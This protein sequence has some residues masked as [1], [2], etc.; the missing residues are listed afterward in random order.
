MRNSLLEEY[1]NK[2]VGEYGVRLLMVHLLLSIGFICLQRY[3]IHVAC[4][5]GHLEMIKLLID[6]HCDI[7]CQDKYVNNY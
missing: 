2:I 5:G 1:V 7:E 3:P 6:H 4:L